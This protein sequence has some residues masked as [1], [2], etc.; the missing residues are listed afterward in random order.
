MD[1]IRISEETIVYRNI[2]SNVLRG[3][4]KNLNNLRKEG[5]DR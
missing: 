3:F 1:P 5:S 4:D 2:E